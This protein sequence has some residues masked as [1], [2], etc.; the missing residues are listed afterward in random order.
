[1]R[2][3]DAILIGAGQ[4]APSLAVELAQ[5][6]Q[7]LA[8]IEGNLL[9]G[10]CVNVGCT[11]TKTLR[12]S[13]RVAH[14]ARRAAEFGV[15]TGTV[16]VDFAAA[17]QR[18][19]ARVETSRQGLTGWLQATK[20]IDTIHGWGRFIGRDGDKFLIEVN[21]ETLSADRVY[22]NTGARAVIPEL[23]GIDKVPYLDNVSVLALTQCPEHLLIVGASY[24]GLE[25]GQIFRRLG[26]EVS[27][28]HRA[29]RI[30]EREDEEISEHIAAFLR[31]EGI[32]FHLNSSVSKLIGED[33]GL[34]VQLSDG[35]TLNGS[36]ILFASGRRPNTERLNLA[37][38]GVETD[39]RGF[40]RTDAHFNTNVKGIKALGDVNGRGAFTHTSYHD[41]QI[42]LAEIDGEHPT[43]Q[44]QDA[45]KRV[46]SYAMFTDPPLGR[47]GI[48]LAQAQVLA[49]KGQKILVADI[50]MADVSRAKEEDE[51]L[52]MM[53]VIVD[54]ESE[55]F[56]GAAILGIGGDEIIAVITNFMATGASYR[57]MQQ[58]LPVH[59]T[60]AEFFPTLLA[61][62]RELT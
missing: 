6:G 9:G 2:H 32:A 58:A 57:L 12:K 62:L 53:R 46:L 3:F 27:I 18:M 54:A 45:D 56:L 1:M 33:R 36:H 19:R 29:G 34:T 38:V 7:R 37:A 26:A 13:A 20:N 41:Q 59:P 40:I 35:R 8:L 17:M 5:R 11:P 48:T 43:G 28:I 52:G 47:V 15:L 50:A 39:A 31:A 44:W 49:G 24:I 14:M 61:R 51:T 4:A 16:S 22:L 30:A 60:V 42:V 25:M 21:G 10:T 23:P 55:R